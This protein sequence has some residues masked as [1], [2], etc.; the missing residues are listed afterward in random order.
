MIVA[1]STAVVACAGLGLVLAAVRSGPTGA[2]TRPSAA[3]TQVVV[4]STRSRH[5][6][7]RDDGAERYATGAAST[8]GD[9]RFSYVA[10]S[11]DTVLGIASRFHVC[12]SDVAGGFPLAAQGHQLTAGLPITVELGPWP[13]QADGTVDCVED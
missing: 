1:V 7:A 6:V 5:L 4:D 12:A 8:I 11:G 3:R 10:A 9:G 2:A 13:L